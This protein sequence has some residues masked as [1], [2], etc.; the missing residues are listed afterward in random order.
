VKLSGVP[1]EENRVGIARGSLSHPLGRLLA[2]AVH[3]PEGGSVA[4]KRHKAGRCKGGHGRYTPPSTGVHTVTFELDP[5]TATLDGEARDWAVD[6]FAHCRLGICEVPNLHTALHENCVD[7]PG[8]GPIEVDGVRDWSATKAGRHSVGLVVLDGTYCIFLAASGEDEE[9]AHAGLRTALADWVEE[10]IGK[11]G[12]LQ[13]VL[14]L[15]KD[16][17]GA[18]IDHQLLAGSPQ[19]AGPVIKE[20]ERWRDGYFHEGWSFEL[21]VTDSTA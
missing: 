11:V 15:E 10:L 16:G 20:Y 7:V 18:F 8:V 14:A 12:I 19:P 13:L 3:D 6:I 9:D 17:P 4:K 21:P 5:D 1:V 2:T